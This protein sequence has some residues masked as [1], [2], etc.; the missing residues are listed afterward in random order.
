M[1]VMCGRASPSSPK[2]RCPARADS[3]R[4]CSLGRQEGRYDFALDTATGATVALKFSADE[5]G[6][7]E[8]LLSLR[9]PQSRLFL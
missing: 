8:G 3:G 7:D 2:R 5:A 6:L 9:L 1:M 4:W